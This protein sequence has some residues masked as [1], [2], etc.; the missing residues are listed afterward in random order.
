MGGGGMT[1]YLLKVANLGDLEDIN[2]AKQ[3]L[4]LYDENCNTSLGCDAGNVDISTGNS[5][6]AVGGMSLMNNTNGFGNT[7]LGCEALKQNTKGYNN[8][9]VGGGSTPTKHRRGLQ[10]GGGVCST[11]K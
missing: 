2:E 3:N 9:A 10:C 11:P 7:A 8:V 1:P 5:N 4:G 6:T